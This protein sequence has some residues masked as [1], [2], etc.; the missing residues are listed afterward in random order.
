[1]PVYWLKGFPH[2]PGSAGSI[3]PDY[4]GIRVATF[5]DIAKKAIPSGRI[6]KLGLVG[7]SVMP[8]PVTTAATP[9]YPS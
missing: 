5:K 7:Y 2:I 9:G 3:T 4:P 1:M 6:R 8:L